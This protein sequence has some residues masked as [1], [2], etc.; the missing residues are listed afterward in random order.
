MPDLGR[1]RRPRFPSAAERVLPTGLRV[2]AVR[3]PSVPL[4]QVRLR[5][6]LAGRR[7]D[8]LARTEV[9]RRTILRGTAERSATRLAQDLQAVGGALA[10]DVDT[11]RLVLSGEALRTGLTDLL[12]I[13]AEV[14]SG[15]T[16][17][18]AEVEA[19]RARA[20]DQT[21]RLL[22]TPGV[23]ADEALSYRMFGDHPYGRDHPHPDEVAAVT[24][25]SVRSLH[26]R[27][28]VPAGSVL[29]LVGDVT[30]ARA[31]DQVERA[32]A[33][34]D[35]EGSAASMPKVP[36]TEPGPLTLV[37][38]PGAVQST[39]RLGGR[40]PDR[41]AEGYAALKLANTV[42]GGYF[43][44]RM[45]QNIREDKGYTYSPRSAV[46]H[47][48]AASVLVVAAD[49][50]TEVTAPALV[51]IGYELG[52]IAT[53]PVTQEE[54]DMAKRYAAGSLALATS[55]QAGLA[56]TLLELAAVGLDLTWLREHLAET[57][58]ATREQVQ[59]QA[60]R[61]LA[62]AAFVPVVLGDAD[63][64]GADLEA[65]GPVVPPG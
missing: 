32:M 27:R 59:E 14:M 50:A 36:A 11:D 37:P 63:Q 48:E 1:P 45:V 10:V 38:R 33:G 20:A 40:A 55:T 3:R 21:R 47:A 42:F 12:A 31:L 24:A 7:Q 9:L 65:L 16:H 35:R 39:I 17:P 18:T 28:L 29:V 15:A 61:Y 46:Q 54:L 5:V 64:V 8:H 44:S 43:S 13:V 4:V 52:R 23:L 41:R 49:V 51:E 57:E 6:P 56:A 60:R 2:V 19:E 22:T 53:L 34:W 25:A 62:P 26:R 58:K 30:P